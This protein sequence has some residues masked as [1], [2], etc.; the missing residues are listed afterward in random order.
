MDFSFLVLK[1][2]GFFEVILSDMV[3]Y[4][5]PLLIVY[6]LDILKQKGAMQCSSTET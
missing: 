3:K 1:H 6:T 4:L 2:L 5:H